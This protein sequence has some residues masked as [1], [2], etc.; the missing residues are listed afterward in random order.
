MLSKLLYKFTTT[1]GKNA[2]GNIIDQLIS[3]IFQWYK[4]SGKEESDTLEFDKKLIED[5]LTLKADLTSF[6]DRALLPIK[7]G[8]YAQVTLQIDSAF[9]SILK[10]VLEST[11]YSNFYTYII[12]K[13]PI[14]DYDLHYVIVLTMYSK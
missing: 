2:Q 10:D 8:K 13:W 11:Y 12:H 7:Q 3:Y 4:D 9:A 5:K 1:T 6:L 14:T